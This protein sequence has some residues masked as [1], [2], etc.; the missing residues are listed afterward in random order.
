MVDLFDEVAGDRFQ[1][2][3]F[4]V[5]TGLTAREIESFKGNR[6]LDIL[7]VD[8]VTLLEELEL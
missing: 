4:A 7:V 2:N 6:G 8:P 5:W 3:A 1:A